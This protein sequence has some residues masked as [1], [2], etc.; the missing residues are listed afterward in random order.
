MSI[1]ALSEQLY[2]TAAITSVCASFINDIIN[3]LFAHK[4]FFSV[5]RDIY[6]NAIVMSERRRDTR[7]CFAAHKFVCIQYVLRYE[8][9]VV[10]GTECRRKNRD[11]RSFRLFPERRRKENVWKCIITAQYRFII[12]SVITY[13]RCHLHFY[14]LHF[15]VTFFGSNN[16]IFR[17][18][19]SI[20]NFFI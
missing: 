20:K 3:V 9:F 17:H 16:Y 6:V 1:C 11:I 14:H 4:Y 5:T 12:H 19:I 7:M 2:F 13:I 8:I 15:Y 18:L 10:D